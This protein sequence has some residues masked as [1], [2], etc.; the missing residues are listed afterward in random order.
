MYLTNLKNNA[1]AQIGEA[2]VYYKNARP[3]TTRTMDLG[4]EQKRLSINNMIFPILPIVVCTKFSVRDD[5][6]DPVTSNRSYIQ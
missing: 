2:K 4:Y 3:N 1:I 5:A 6:C